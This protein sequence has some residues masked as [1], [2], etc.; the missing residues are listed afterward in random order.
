MLAMGDAG[1]REDAAATGETDEPADLRE[2]LLREPSRPDPAVWWS[3][4]TAS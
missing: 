1:A 4:R 3:P 2:R